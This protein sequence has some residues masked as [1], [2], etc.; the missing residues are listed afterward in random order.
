MGNKNST[1]NK[2]ND[3]FNGPMKDIGYKIG[4]YTGKF[5]NMGLGIMNNF[6]NLTNNVSN[7]MGTSY[8]PIILLCIGGVFVMYKLKMF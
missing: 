3:F 5:A 8:F 7:F 2:I 4:E 6:M 1:T